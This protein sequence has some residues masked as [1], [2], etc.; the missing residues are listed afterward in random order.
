MFYANRIF[1]QLHA[2]S[3]K[4]LKSAEMTTNK[5][6][7]H[8]KFTETIL[9]QRNSEY[10]EKKKI[11]KRKKKKK[12]ME[13]SKRQNFKIC[14]MSMGGNDMHRNKL[15]EISKAKMKCLKPSKQK[16]LMLKIRKKKKTIS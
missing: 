9:V 5:C 16:K 10:L 12:K 8:G 15:V 11:S 7:A 4:Y 13:C 6:V 2:K 3:E 14:K 1:S